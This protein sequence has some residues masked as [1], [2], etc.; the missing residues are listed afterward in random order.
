MIVGHRIRTYP[1]DEAALRIPAQRVQ[2]VDSVRGVVEVL[3]SMMRAFDGI[4]LAATQVEDPS[5]AVQGWVQACPAMFVM[6]RE[7]ENLVCINPEIVSTEGQLT[8]DEGCLSF[9]SVVWPLAAPEVVRLRY[10]GLDGGTRE[11]VFDGWLARCAFHET[12]HLA[13]KLMIDRMARWERRRFIRKV[14]A[15]RRGK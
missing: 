11:E 9:A 3:I 8:K 13:G 12:D 6:A 10:M 15:E 5:W 1:E 4:G 14:E 2:N 7:D